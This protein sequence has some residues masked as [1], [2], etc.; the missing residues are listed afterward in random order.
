M[1]LRHIV[2]SA[3]IIVAILLGIF[4]IYTHFYRPATH[5]LNADLQWLGV[6]DLDN[7]HDLSLNAILNGEDGI[8]VVDHATLLYQSIIQKI[9][10]AK[11]LTP[12]E[13]FNINNLHL[14]DD[15]SDTLITH[16]DAIFKH[17]FVIKF[18][19]NGNQND[20]KSLPAAG[21]KGIYINHANTTGD[22]S[23]LMTDGSTRTLVGTS[24]LEKAT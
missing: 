19:D 4:Q 14:L 22:Y 10:Q 3:I 9:P 6:I 1:T 8:L 23:I 2:I 7:G 24:K 12:D 20:I 13:V 21:I 5:S 18:Y 15:N 16:K 17:L 11:Q